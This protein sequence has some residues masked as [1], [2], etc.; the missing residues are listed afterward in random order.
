MKYEVASITDDGIK[1]QYND[2]KVL[3]ALHVIKHSVW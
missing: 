2:Y 1:N 3:K